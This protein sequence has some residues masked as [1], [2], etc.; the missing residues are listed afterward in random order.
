LTSG[1]LTLL[2]RGKLAI[3]LA[4]GVDPREVPGKGLESQ[5]T[6]SHALV[7]AEKQKVHASQ[8]GDG[9]LELGALEVD[10]SGNRG[11]FEVTRN[12]E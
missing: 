11:H 1:D 2:R 4:A 10:E 3:I 8:E 9:D 7:V 6:A 12:R 5:E